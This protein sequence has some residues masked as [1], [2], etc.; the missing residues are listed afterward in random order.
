M[1]F[2]ERDFSSAFAVETSVGGKTRIKS[3]LEIEVSENFVGQWILPKITIP[4][5]MD[6]VL[7]S[8]GYEAPNGTG[9]SITFFAAMG[10]I[11]WSDNDS[12]DFKENSI[13]GGP[14]GIWKFYIEYEKSAGLFSS[15]QVI[16]FYCDIEI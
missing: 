16:I 15:P 8:A 13:I 3:E 7:M 6:P 10:T 2:S 4:F 5:T 14:S 12:Q 11:I 9:D 1:F